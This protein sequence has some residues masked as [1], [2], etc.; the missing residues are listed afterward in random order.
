M[1]MLRPV[2]TLLEVLG[3]STKLAKGVQDNNTQCGADQVSCKLALP[4]IC[5]PTTMYVIHT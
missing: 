2:R 4:L 5:L 1:H 3:K